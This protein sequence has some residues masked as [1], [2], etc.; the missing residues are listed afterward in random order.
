M[1]RAEVAMTLALEGEG[2]ENTSEKVGGEETQRK[3]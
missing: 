3:A 1:S 2:R